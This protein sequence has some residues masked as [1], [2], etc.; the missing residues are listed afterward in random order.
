MKASD[1]PITVK[2]QFQVSKDQ[3]WKAI[4]SQPELIQW[5]FEAIEEFEP[6]VGFSTKFI[7]EN[8]GRV[9]PHCWEIVEVIPAK[10]I[11]YTWNYE[12]YPGDS[13]VSFQINKFNERVEL[14]VTHKVT[15]DFPD[16]IPEFQR[17]SCQGGWEYFIKDR[18]KTYFL[19]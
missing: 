4:T 1:S 15:E 17:E 16:D 3:L 7:V 8:E 6:I 2:Q 11:D 5:F 12:G 10:R 9:F 19:S 14:V 13:I 18:L